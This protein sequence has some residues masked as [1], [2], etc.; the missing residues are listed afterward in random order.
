MI[1][2]DHHATTPCDERV[3]EAMLPYFAR[4]FGNAA[5]RTHAFGWRAE[6]A[7]EIAREVIAR[8]IGAREPREVVFTSGATE[9]NNLAILG[10]ARARRGRG[11][12]V[13]ALASE[14]SSVLEPCQALEREGFRVT[15]VSVGPDGL[16]D[17]DAVADAITERTLLVTA[18]AANNEIGVLQPLDAIARVARERGVLFHS[19]AAQAVGKV[20]VDVAATGIDLLSLTAHKLYGPKGVGALYVRAGRPR[21]RI[22]P[23]LYGGGHEQGLRPGTLPV[24]LIVGFGRAVEI[25]CAEREV[26]A[27]RLAAQRDR[28]LERLRAIGGV[29]LNG[30][31]TRRLPGNLNVSIEGVEADALV[32]ALRDVAISTGSACASAKPEPSHVLRALG[33]PDAAVRASIRIGLGRGTTDAEVETAGARIADEVAALRAAR[34]A[35]TLGRPPTRP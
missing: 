9:S 34:S 26:E 28:L 11:D 6:A 5:S 20:P 8:A 25:A 10:A 24:P 23:L 30:H 29:S 3:V 33:L 13:V 4:E 16:A 35:A 1:Y 32:A 12:H 17:P 7:V 31:P 27:K 22:E 15:L 19:D 18:M 2:L 21:I 14:H